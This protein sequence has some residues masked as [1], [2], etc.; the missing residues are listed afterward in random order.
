MIAFSGLDGAGKSTQIELLQKYFTTKGIDSFILWSR[1]G[2][3]PG[4]NSLK[5][6][7][8]FTGNKNIPQKNGSSKERDNLFKN[9]FVRKMWLFL[10]LLDLIWF[11]IVYIRIKEA[12]GTQIICDRY[13]FDTSIDFKLNYKKDKVESR[14]LWKVMIFL[15]KKP[16]KHFVFTITAKESL[17]RSKLKN[18]PFPDSEE[19]LENR[20]N[21]YLNFIA[22]K[23]EIIHIDGNI[24]IEETHNFITQELTK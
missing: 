17:I 4:I 21:D 9:K 3:T 1:G 12:I 23:K 15:A 11:Y 22:T 2:Y 8:R 14:L 19:T 20:L 18:E 10:A 7:L 24:S 6:L 16:K 5:K 13:I